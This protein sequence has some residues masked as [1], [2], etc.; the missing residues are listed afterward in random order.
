MLSSC[1][2]LCFNTGIMMGYLGGALLTYE[3][4][5]YVML[6]LPVLFLCT[7]GFLP[8]SSQHLLRKN[9]T[10]VYQITLRLN[11]N[12][13]KF[14]SLF[15]RKLKWLFDSIGIATTI[16]QR[17]ARSKCKLNLKNSKLFL[18]KTKLT[19]ALHYLTFV[20]IIFSSKTVFAHT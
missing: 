3:V 9:K 13:D 7:F 18:S 8:N 6:S 5:P 4:E 14:Y 19:K 1:L 15:F 2:T 12:L 20:R 16:A 11:M 10:A 17:T